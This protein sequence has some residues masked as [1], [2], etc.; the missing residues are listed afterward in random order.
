MSKVFILSS[1]L[2]P[3]CLTLGSKIYCVCDVHS[4]PFF[5]QFRM[6]ASFGQIMW[7]L[8]VDLYLPRRQQPLRLLS[9]DK[10][11]SL[12]HLAKSKV[13][14]RLRYRFGT[15]PTTP[16]SMFNM[17]ECL[18]T[19]IRTTVIQYFIN[20]NFSIRTNGLNIRVQHNS[21]AQVFKN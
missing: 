19:F 14:E 7:R 16:I 17:Q 18:L 21:Y 8:F 6:N 12:C 1:L 11:A 10:M 3:N 20:P 13:K 2:P 4:L 15:E 9:A 5:L